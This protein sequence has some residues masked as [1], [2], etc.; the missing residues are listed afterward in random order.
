ML[1]ALAGHVLLVKVPSSLALQVAV[2]VGGVAALVV[3]AT[4]LTRI[5]IASRSQPKLF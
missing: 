2:S 4:L 5:K 3:F 1:L